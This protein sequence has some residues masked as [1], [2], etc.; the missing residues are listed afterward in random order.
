MKKQ[1]VVIGLGQFG[2]G[3]LK[4]LSSLETELIAIDKNKEKVQIASQYSSQVFCFD[5]TE[6]EA[7]AQLDPGSRDVCVCATGDQSKEV[8]IICTALLKQMG[9]K[10]VIAR[11]NDDLHSRILK[12]VGADEVINP[13]WDFGAKF[14]NRIMSENILA[15]MSLGSDLTVTE[16]KAPDRFW[17]KSLIDLDL[18]R[19]Y[20]ITVIAVR[21]AASGTVK[22]AR[23]DEII[24]DGD[25]LIVV[26]PPGKIEKLLST[27][28]L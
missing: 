6:G 10:R 4:A 19:N 1:I 22:L 8:A 15:E 25:I 17:K 3:L 18:R 5:A 23:A 28:S 21:S 13:E 14:A 12:L 2:L 26:S 24:H 7:L 9:A 11:A 20:G 16:F 27:Y